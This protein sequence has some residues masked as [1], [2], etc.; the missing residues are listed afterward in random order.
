M[1]SRLEPHSEMQIPHSMN[2]SD[3]RMS[4]PPITGRRL[5]RIY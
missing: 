1:M 5:V 2:S 3:T 4:R